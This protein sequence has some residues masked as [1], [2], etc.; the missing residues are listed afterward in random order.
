[1]TKKLLA[2][3]LAAAIPFSLA[4]CS[5]SSSSTSSSSQAAPASSAPAS[6]AAPADSASEA[7]DASAYEV[8][9]PITIQF[10]HS[11]ANETKAAAMAKIAEDFNASQDMVTVEA[12][13]MGSYAAI[14]EQFM[15]A[16][17]AKTG[18]PGLCVINYPQIPVYAINGVAE[19]LDPYIQASGFDVEDIVDG[20][21]SPL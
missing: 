8:T 16:Q 1:M 9:E 18:L 7:A 20:F 10:W 14:E 11:L 2:L 21:I 19:S 5:G 3:L 13:Y 15:A 12:S 6:S 4:A 17:M